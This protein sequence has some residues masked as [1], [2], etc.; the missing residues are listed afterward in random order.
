MVV[1]PIICPTPCVAGSKPAEGTPPVASLLGVVGE[2]GWNVAPRVQDTPD[3]EPALALH[4]EDE[5]W[6]PREWP[7]S[8]SGDVEFIG[9]PEG[10]AVGVA[11]DVSDATFEGVDDPGGDGWFDLGQV[12]SKSGVDVVGSEPA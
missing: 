6:V 3:V 11:A 8:E 4:V 7:R 10:A 1:C 9:E 5:V 2:R 12:V